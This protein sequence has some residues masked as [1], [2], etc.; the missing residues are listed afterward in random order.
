MHFEVE[1]YRDRLG[2]NVWYR[3]KWVLYKRQLKG[4]HG[5]YDLKTYELRFGWYKL[6]YVLHIKLMYLIEKPRKGE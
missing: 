1:F 4:N 3:P 6:Y 5:G 2:M